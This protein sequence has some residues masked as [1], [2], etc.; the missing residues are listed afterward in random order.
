[1]CRIFWCLDAVQLAFRAER[2]QET[3]YV[4][5]TLSEGQRADPLRLL[6]SSYPK[7]AFKPYRMK[8]ATASRKL[9][10]TYLSSLLWKFGLNNERALDAYELE[11]CWRSCWSLYFFNT[12]ILETSSS[13]YC[14]AKQKNKT[15]RVLVHPTSLP[16]KK[17]PHRRARE[18]MVHQYD[19]EILAH[20][21]M[22]GLAPPTKPGVCRWHDCKKKKKSTL[23]CR[24]AVGRRRHQP[25]TSPCS[26]DA[27]RF[28]E[29]TTNLH[30]P[31]AP[32]CQI[33]KNDPQYQYHD[34]RDS[35]AYDCNSRDHW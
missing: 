20:R 35:R 4:G 30:P 26:N 11:D 2:D 16:P 24:T 13:F 15:L 17:R 5:L 1:V 18:V 7:A 14:K 25:P 23:D 33:A 28:D 29:G 21:E 3:T 22:H 32:K 12:I 31:S 19:T 34:T 10:G 9:N 8:I 6:G 27:R